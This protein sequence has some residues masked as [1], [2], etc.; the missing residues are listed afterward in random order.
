MLRWVGSIGIGPVRQDVEGVSFM[1]IVENGTELFVVLEA[2]DYED[3]ACSVV[4]VV[5]ED[6]DD[7]KWY[8]RQMRSD[9]VGVRQVPFAPR[10]RRDLV[11]EMQVWTAEV[12]VKP[13]RA[14]TPAEDWH[15]DPVRMWSRTEWRV[16]DPSV[17]A[18]VTRSGESAGALA[19]GRVLAWHVRAEG[20]TRGATA[21]ALDEKLNVL[22]RQLA[23]G[24]LDTPAEQL[25]K[26]EQR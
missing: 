13:V 9:A 1:S 12:D 21:Q 4:H 24:T 14:D 2:P 17:S 6:Q 22:L 18:A 20:P 23:D 10:G 15:V 16:D 8:A 19:E 3:G 5:C 25:R 7:A 11:V 26:A